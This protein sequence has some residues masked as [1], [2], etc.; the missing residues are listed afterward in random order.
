MIGRLLISLLLTLPSLQTSYFTNLGKITNRG[1][2]VTLGWNNQVNDFSYGI[3]ANYSYNKNFVNS[4]GDKID[5]KITGNEGANITE[6][7]KSIGYFYGYKQV[8]IYQTLADLDKMPKF[9]DS[10]PG[11][12]ALQISMAMAKLALRI[13]LT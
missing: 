2:E 3:N 4:I 11:D 7:G 5:F 1:I 13:E 12:I 10:A 6:T 8:G 9:A